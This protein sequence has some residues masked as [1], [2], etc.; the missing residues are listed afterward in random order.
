MANGDAAAA[1]G[2]DVV[3]AT[4]QRSLGY[5]EI[6]K[7]RD[8][9]VQHRHPPTPTN[10]GGTGSTNVYFQT[11][12]SSGV[13]TGI[14]M[15]KSDGTMARGAG[16]LPPSYIPSLAELAETQPAVAELLQ[17]VDD[18]LRRVKQLEADR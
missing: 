4:A 9:L 8:Y 14:V 17:T 5:D 11:T 12:P 3:P 13:N 7:S 1:A 18:L 16:A 6:N 2:L 15:V 10:K